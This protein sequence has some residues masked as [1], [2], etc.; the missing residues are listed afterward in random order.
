MEYMK[1]SELAFDPRSQMGKIFADGFYEHGLKHFSKD[2]AKLAKALS[3]IFVL[4]SFFV[5]VE[6]EE[7][8]AFVGCTAKK[9]P[10][11]KLD[12]KTLIRELGIIRG[13][14]A[15]WGLNKFM[16]NHVYP[17]ELSPQ[18]GSIEFVATASEYRGKGAAFGLL[19]HVMEISPYSE[20]VLEVIDTNDPAIRLYEK[21]GY[22]EFIRTP[23][24][25]GS[26]FNHF[27][28][29]KNEQIRGEWHE[30]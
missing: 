13:R 27:V 26:G 5:A 22:C 1:A 29:M 16:V 28:Y 4:D 10:P 15:N 12:K 25:K 18:T 23:A 9:P 11:V 8:M 7:I 14:I 20:F 19:S 24:P 6:G 30:V 17:F 21:L 2:K 3:H